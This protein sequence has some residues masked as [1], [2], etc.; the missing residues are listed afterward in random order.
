M[1]QLSD[2]MSKRKSFK[3]DLGDLLDI[4]QNKTIIRPKSIDLTLENRGKDFKLEYK[5]VYNQKQA[6]ANQEWAIST[7]LKSLEQIQECMTRHHKY[8][9][10]QIKQ[11]KR[12]YHLTCFSDDAIAFLAVI[13]PTVLAFGVREKKEDTSN[14]S[15]LIETILK[16]I[17][18][19][20]MVDD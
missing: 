10:C 20:N 7:V 5:E 16:W 13:L 6:P 3:I 12:E 4:S 15:S 11:L 9:Y 14:T 2:K 17:S 18:K 1:L 19:A 8:F